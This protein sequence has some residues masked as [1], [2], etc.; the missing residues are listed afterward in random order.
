MNDVAD[1]EK[2]AAGYAGLAH[3][4]LTECKTKTNISDLDTAIYLFH[5]AAYSCQWSVMHPEF[6]RILDGFAEALLTR[7]HFTAD[8]EDLNWAMICRSGGIMDLVKLSDFAT[9]PE[10]YD[11]SPVE[12]DPRDMMASAF[13]ILEDFHRSFDSEALQRIVSL[14]QKALFVRAPSH[15]D[16][17]KSLFELSE[18]LL[19]Q[20]RLDGKDEQYRKALSL[21]QDLHQVQPNR[22]LYLCAAFLVR[23]DP[24]TILEA[25]LLFQGMRKSALE[26]T[27]L[28]NSVD[29]YAPTHSQL[30]RAVCTL[31]KA[32]SAFP[33]GFAS[34]KV[35]LSKLGNALTEM[36]KMAH[37][38][39]IDEATDLQWEALGLCSSPDPYRAT[40][41]R[42]LG[43]TLRVR[44]DKRGA[45]KDIEDAVQA[46]REALAHHPP[47]H[48]EREESLFALGFALKSR[49]GW[50][51]EVEDIN[52]AIGLFR[53]VRALCPPGNPSHGAAL[54]D[55]AM[56]LQARAYPQDID[57]TVELLRESVIF[58]SKVAPHSDTSNRQW[59]D[60]SSA[61]ATMLVTRYLQNNDLQDIEEAIQLLRKAVNSS[62]SYHP[63]YSSLLN[64]LGVAFSTRFRD[65]QHRNLHDADDAIKA[66]EEAL[67]VRPLAHPKHARALN[68]LAN[69]LQTRFKQLKSESGKSD[70]D[71][72]VD[73]H[74]RALTL[75]PVGDPGRGNSL[76]NL[77]GA[78]MS[79]FEH[80]TEQEDID[81]AVEMSREALDLHP[82]PHPQHGMYLYNLGSCFA[83]YYRHMPDLDI[84]SKAISNL[85]GATVY[86]KDA[87]SPF[88]QFIYAQAWADASDE[89]KHPSS[90]SAY[91]AVINLLPQL[92]ALHLDVGSR[93]RILRNTNITGLASRA[94]A[95]AADQEQYERAVE[96]LEAGRSVFW[97]QALQLRNNLHDLDINPELS[98][99][100]VMLSNELEQVSF[101]DSTRNLSDDSQETFISIE[102]AGAHFR[103]LNRE[104][105][106]TVNSVRLRCAGQEDFMR[107]KRMTALRHGA[108]TG[109]VVILNVGETLTHVL[110]VTFS[111]GVQCLALPRIRT[112]WV[113]FL[114]DTLRR[115][116]SSTSVH[117]P[118]KRP[119]TGDT[120]GQ[121]LAAR[122]S[123][124]KE[125]DYVAD[126][127]DIFRGVLRII[128][129][130]IAKPVIDALGWKKSADLP[131]LWWCPTGSLAFLPIHAAGVYGE[132]EVDCVS[133][134][135]ISSYTP[136]LSALLDAPT[137]SPKPFKM[138]TVIQ[139]YSEFSPLPCADE[140]LERIKERVPEQMRATVGSNAT[141]Q[142]ILMH[143]RESAIVHFACH[144]LQ[145]LEN[146]LDSALILSSGRLKISEIMRRP[147]G[148]LGRRRASMSL[149]VLM[150]CETAK[151]DTSVPD[152]AMHLA[153][154]LLF[155]GFR[156]VVA[157]MWTMADRDGPK[158]AD[159]FYEYLFRSCDTSSHPPVLEVPHLTDAAKAL[160][161]AVI[162]LRKEPDITFARWVPFIH[163]GL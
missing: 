37:T 40:I 107:P 24:E 112:A 52:A 144:G 65:P 19:H 89:F 120:E 18:A 127:N 7:F 80:F 103:R 111:G 23:P 148:E 146:P 46:C 130:D 114:V 36:A 135:A 92:A 58:F 62:F 15:P 60:C 162:E 156:G 79:R 49:F 86:A 30:E 136:T 56:A 21:L 47:A 108:A 29:E 4:L 77:S 8:A 98:S 12:D 34:R 152:E 72:A 90:L 69:A 22:G 96:F 75:R 66:Y 124:K 140:E 149:A 95:C 78:L 94:A 5:H 55:L 81:D 131:R 117:I 61:L 64:N 70:I 88:Y 87:Q 48:P 42:N 137:E 2:E 115:A 1:I 13:G 73:L 57:E 17:W 134:Y 157:T 84:L 76:T 102:A 97:A 14:Y 109:P 151:G 68:N 20:F 33:C 116:A 139:P 141:A 91:H 158:V 110:I 126:S 153:A 27:E 143:L 121:I 123:G 67:E 32:E 82:P 125:G 150:A 118:M 159:K 44:F 133:D 160:H 100:I 16:R 138:T 142:S 26:A 51:G 105:E 38:G 132:N 163:Y 99:K 39:Y 155:A 154:T 101:R 113:N 122:L 50:K 147:E 104:W 9:N 31:R 45:S 10:A 145:N 43:R 161:L 28:A 93:L 128:W 85:Q 74:R 11:L 106:K 71:R 119:R 54:A 53:E 83:E 63:D 25:L 129:E 59:A 3:D 41:L 6:L 35:L